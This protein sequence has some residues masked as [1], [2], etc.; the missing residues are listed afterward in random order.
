M[1]NKNI[2][3]IKKVLD[4]NDY[5]LNN[6]LC[7]V[8]KV[9]KFQSICLATGFVKACGYSTLEVL[10]VII[11]MPLMLMKSVNAF[12]NSEFQNITTMK[13]DVIF[14]L[15]NNENMNWRK[16]QYC[17]CKQFK[18][19]TNNSKEIDPNSAFI[20][21]DTSSIKT[22]KTIEN[23]SIIHNHTSTEKRFNLG[24]KTLVLGYYDG[25][26]MIPVDFSIHSEKKLSLKDRK[27]QYK[28]DCKHNSSGAVRRRECSVDKITNTLAMV[29]RA[30]K[31]GFIAKYV[32][33]D[34]WFIGEKFI[35]AIRQIK[36]GAMHVIAGIKM[37]KRKYTY[38]DQDF[39]GKELLTKMQIEGKAIRCRK[40]NIRYFEIIVSY[41]N[42][43]SIK[44]FFCRFPYQK[45]WRIFVSTDVNLSFV[46]M[47]E[48]YK[49]RW[50]IEIFF[51]EVKQFLQFGKC[52]SRDF[53]AQI[54]STTLCFL[55][56]TFLAYYRSISAYK[57]LDGLFKTIKDDICE[58][59]LAER[60]WIIFEELLDTVI[61]SISKSGVVDIL[62]FK[63][64]KEY[65]EAK[66]V[67]ESSFLSTQI[68]G[69]RKPA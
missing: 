31:N 13:K 59:T 4:R 24:Y 6:I 11:M 46:Q 16:L 7:D 58:K 52:Q 69:L 57:S 49:N 37:D 10:T 12:Y 62:S 2:D 22:G 17:V 44:L 20:I 39:T 50:I 33:A 1:K 19:L 43:G 67:L 28:K 5:D 14:R 8:M 54:A 56:Y 42:S 60:L 27:K 38:K 40:W 25:K 68:F 34:S 65:N 55:L 63:Q 48:I 64:S 32:L 36:N 26:V 53:D 15:K 3:E 35:N 21:D 30:V 45:K 51:K 23:I 18:K 29:K 61:S 47:M 41:K 66:E 9:F